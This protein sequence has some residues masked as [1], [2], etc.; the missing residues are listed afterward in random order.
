M[1][2][3]THKKEKSNTVEREREIQ[4]REAYD[5]SQNGRNRNVYP[6][7]VKA[8]NVSL[9]ATTTIASDGSDHVGGGR[10]LFLFSLSR[11]NGSVFYR[12]CAPFSVSLDRDTENR[13]VG[14]IGRS[15]IRSDR[16]RAIV[17]RDTGATRQK[18]R[19]RKRGK[20]AAVIQKEKEENKRER[21]IT[22]AN[23]IS[24]RSDNNHGDA[25]CSTPIYIYWLPVFWFSFSFFFFI[26]FCGG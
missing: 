12:T 22:G 21:E 20:G 10:L 13:G 3:K 17:L 19:E 16:I 2:K 25:N 11:V 5:G 9:A 7:N 14:D 1:E 23:I 18:K 6:S 8:I 4:S 24:C 26:Y 15:D